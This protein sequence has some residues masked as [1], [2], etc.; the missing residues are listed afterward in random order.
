MLEAFPYFCAHAKE[1]L[2]SPHLCLFNDRCFLPFV[3]NKNPPI[4]A[5]PTVP[6]PGSGQPPSALMTAFR[7]NGPNLFSRTWLPVSGSA[8]R[9]GAVLYDGPSRSDAEG[10]D[11]RV[12]CVEGC[13]RGGHRLCEEGWFSACEGFPFSRSSSGYFQ[14]Y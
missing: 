8:V 14:T 4:P 12:G 1:S 10:E 6:S 9:C 11:P 7:L 5:A 13:G 2:I 3:K